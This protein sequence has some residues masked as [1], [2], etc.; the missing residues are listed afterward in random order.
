M[1]FLEEIMLQV[2]F[3]FNARYINGSH[4][5]PSA[6]PTGTHE[7]LVYWYSKDCEVYDMETEVP[8]ALRLLRTPT[9]RRIKER[10]PEIFVF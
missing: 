9:N 8:V 10:A 1:K 2:L 7:D 4:F 3:H 6:R 5:Q